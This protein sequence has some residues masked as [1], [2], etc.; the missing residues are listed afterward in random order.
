M[1]TDLSDTLGSSVPLLLQVGEYSV[2]IAFSKDS[3]DT[4][5]DRIQLLL[6]RQLQNRD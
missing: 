5:E 1:T 3:T 6:Y 2:E 4:L